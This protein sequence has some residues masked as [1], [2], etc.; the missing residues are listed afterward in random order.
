MAYLAGDDPEPD[1]AGTGQGD[2]PA[3]RSETVPVERVVDGDT[4][5]VYY[6]GRKEYVR[7]IGI[8]TPESA[9]PDRPEECFGP[10]AAALNS[11][12]VSGGTVRLEFD[13]ELRDR[14]GRLLAYVYADG[15]LVNAELL[16]RGYA[17]TMTIPPNDS[18]SDRFDRLERDARNADRGLWSECR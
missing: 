14:F 7:Y 8:D 5:L 4:L 6:E 16:R 13:R 9:I 2:G 1:R 17:E 18:R 12:L 3:A 11:A 15:L 10:E